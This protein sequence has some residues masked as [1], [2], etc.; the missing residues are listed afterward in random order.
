MM[1]DRGALHVHARRTDLIVTGGENVYPLE[2]EERLESL[3][4]VRRALVFGVPDERWGQIVAAAMELSPG[5]TL[6]EVAARAAGMLAPHKRPRRACTVE[7][8]PLTG[9]GKLDRS[10][11]VERYAAALVPFVA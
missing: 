10:K 9:S 3:P 6:A 8:L 4:G 11:A 1:D 7:E 5:V 2:I